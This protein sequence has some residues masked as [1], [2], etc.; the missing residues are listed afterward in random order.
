MFF[1]TNST[2]F[3]L[4]HKIVQSITIYHYNHY[5]YTLF[6]RHQYIKMTNKQL[7]ASVKRLALR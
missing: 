2:S 4:T 1:I 3:N 7:S 6:Q 5:L